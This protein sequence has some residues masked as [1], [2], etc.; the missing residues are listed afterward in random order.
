VWSRLNLLGTEK[1]LIAGCDREIGFIFQA[2][3]PIQGRSR[4]H[5]HP[6]AGEKS[7]IPRG[8]CAERQS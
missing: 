8:E 4:S 6:T 1:T 7:G 5:V 2:F 3:R